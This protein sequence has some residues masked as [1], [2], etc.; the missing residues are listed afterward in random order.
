MPARIICGERILPM[1]EMHERALCAAAGLQS[2]GVGAQDAIAVFL[3]NDFPF[4]EAA[5]AAN[6]L[7]AHLVP[8][9]WHFSAGEAGYVLEDSGAKAVIAHT[10]LAAKLAGVIPAG[11]RLFLVDTPPEIR[12]QFRLGDEPGPR[13]DEAL[14][15][16]PWLEQHEPLEPA[17]V[18]SP[19]SMIY[20]SG[21]TG[22]P[23]GVRR[24]PPTPQEAK[25]IGEILD[26]I[27]PF[28][29]DGAVALVTAP[30]YHSTPNGFFRR[31]VDFG[32]DLVL[33]PRFDPERYLAL[34]DRYRVTHA[35]AV[36]TMFIRMLRLPEEVRRRYDV[37]S[38]KVVVHGAAPTPP[39]VKRRMIDW[40]GPVLVEH[41]GS[42][43]LGAVVACDSH[44]WLAHPGTVGR[45]LPYVDIKVLDDEKRELPPGEPGEIYARMRLYPDFTYQNDP[46]KRAAM[47]HEGLWTAG[48]IG[49]LDA[50]G[51]LYLSDRKRDMVISGGVNIYPLEIEAELHQMPG[52][53]DCAVFGIPDE[54]FGEAVAAV[55]Q[56]QPQVEL[57][58]DDVRAF[59]APRIAGYKMP[60]VIEF[61]DELPREDSG[62]I[63]KRKIRDE[64]WKAAGRNI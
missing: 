43:E 42:T 52:I 59:L 27:M 23:K 1:A 45:P 38:L 28:D 61:R 22:R 57:T 56:P 34:I 2:L 55:V 37:S 10:D 51:Y 54:E 19:G 49:Y 40:F 7:G 35:Y 21:T 30:L 50:D 4:L 16:G 44:E 6:R 32:A 53:V 9:N 5:Y 64:Y 15:W 63:F 8:I 39:D 36:A 12:E 14:Y 58:A 31:A 41:Y 13:F 20:T 29:A 62:K 18:A 46:E 17:E 11:C 60:K 3:R 26:R 48:D 25:G 24:Q 47:E 33:E